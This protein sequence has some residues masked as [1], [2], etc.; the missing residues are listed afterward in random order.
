ML[1][2]PLVAIVDDDE[3][4]RLSTAGLLGRAGFSICSFVDGEQFLASGDGDLCNCVLLDMRMP[5]L[6]GLSII[7]ELRQRPRYPSIVMLAGHG[8]IALAVEAMKLGAFDFLEKPYDPQQL[9]EVLRRACAAYTG[10]PS[11]P[12][13]D[14]VASAQIAAL[15]ERQRAVLT[16]IVNGQPN[17]VIAYELS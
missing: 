13:A 14:P 12:R 6:D 16:G 11:H 15:S 10:L 4:V 7:R 8:N 3:A 9:I 2:E 5:G 17:K 1:Q